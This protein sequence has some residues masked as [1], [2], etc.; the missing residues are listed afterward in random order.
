MLWCENNVIY[1]GGRLD[2]GAGVDD[3]ILVYPSTLVYPGSGVDVGAGVDDNVFVYPGNLVYPS[4][5]GV[6]I[7]RRNIRPFIR[8]LLLACLTFVEKN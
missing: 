2:E 8:T 6:G 1:P 5:S 7:E 4:A 3:I